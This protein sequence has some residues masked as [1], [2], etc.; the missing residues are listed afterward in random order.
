MCLF[1]EG[2]FLLKVVQEWSQYLTLGTKNDHHSSQL[3]IKGD[4]SLIL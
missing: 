4:L 2:K 3:S 1:L